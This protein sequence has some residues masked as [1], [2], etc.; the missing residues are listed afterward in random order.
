MPHAVATV[1]APAVKGRM[2]I[3]T[4]W[5]GQARTALWDP[6]EMRLRGGAVPLER[7]R[8]F[9]GCRRCTVSGAGRGSPGL[10][11]H[12]VTTATGSG[13]HRT[14]VD[15]G[16]RSGNDGATGA[17]L[18]SV[19]SGMEPYWSCAAPTGGIRGLHHRKWESLG[20]PVI[21]RHLGRGHGRSPD[22]RPHGG[23][24]AIRGWGETR[25]LR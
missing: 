24:S 18:H 25:E 16:S 10:A 3:V 23:C 1:S 21:L 13:V 9:C 20:W 12:E 8:P 17:A 2:W 6:P 11:V 22:H 4:G 15:G 7:P 14:S 5:S 19:G